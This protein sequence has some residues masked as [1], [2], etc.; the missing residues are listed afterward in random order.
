MKI[1]THL[2]NKKC[3]F[4]INYRWKHILKFK[5]FRMHLRQCL[6]SGHACCLKVSTEGK[7]L[8]GSL[9]NDAAVGLQHPKNCAKTKE[10]EAS[11]VMTSSI[12]S[13]KL[14]FQ[15]WELRNISFMFE[16]KQIWLFGI[17]E[18]FSL[19]NLWLWEFLREPFHYHCLLTSPRDWCKKKV[20]G[21]EL[22][23]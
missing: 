13:N 15:K 6:T 7:R 2:S 3:V 9:K 10:D 12:S 16:Y 23:Q 20:T 21:P 18:G 11:L 22:D 17:L 19:K 8:L 1:T 5:A 4:S 14:T